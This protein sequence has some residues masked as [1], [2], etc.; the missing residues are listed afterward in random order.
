MI[1]RTQ[2]FEEPPTGA[3]ESMVHG[4]NLSPLEC[5]VA[6][7]MLGD[8]FPQEWPPAA[9]VGAAAAHMQR[10]GA[11]PAPT[12]MLRRRALARCAAC[13]MCVYCRRSMSSVQYTYIPI[14]FHI[15]ASN[16][17]LDLHQ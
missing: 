15:V 6:L 3:L 14:P 5:Y 11:F 12:Q 4:G 9:A 2:E 8:I 7:T 10:A 17:L 13:T 1:C 16:L